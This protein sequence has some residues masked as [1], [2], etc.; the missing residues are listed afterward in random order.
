[1]GNPNKRVTVKTLNLN[2]FFEK[3]G[4]VNYN[5]LFYTICWKKG[6]W[7]KSGEDVDY[8]IGKLNHRIIILFQGT[9]SFK[10]LLIDV[11][12]VPTKYEKPYNG[13]NWRVH[14][15][16]YKAWNSVRSEILNKI[17]YND[18]KLYEDGD[19]FLISGHS[20]GG[21]IATLC[22]EDVGYH[23]ERDMGG[24]APIQL[25]TFGAPRISKNNNGVKALREYITRDSIHF[26]YACDYIPTIPSSYK[27]NEPSYNLGK[28]P[29]FSFLSL[30]N[31]INEYHTNY[32]HINGKNY[33][34]DFVKKIK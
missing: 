23:A 22:A 27:N 20:L 21:A 25:V 31:A 26:R 29:W 8:F 9:E 13:Q 19:T 30:F 4:N 7:V 2:S 34:S 18:N 12:V 32:N 24:R 15:G 6:F 17:F 16:F 10:D 1:M 14:S 5:E 11:M 33:Y 28:K 3:S